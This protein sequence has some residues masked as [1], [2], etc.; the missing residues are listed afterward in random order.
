MFFEYTFMV[1]TQLGMS[2]HVNAYR[3]GMIF[4]ITNIIT[5]SFHYWNITRLLCVIIFRKFHSSVL[6]TKQHYDPSIKWADD[7]CSK[8]WKQKILCKRLQSML[9]FSFN[10]VSHQHKYFNINF[11]GLYF[12]F[13][14]SL[15]GSGEASQKIWLCHANF[16]SLSLFICLEIHCFY[17]LWTRKY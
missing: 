1:M 6:P 8:Y 5:Q 11:I 17:G 12:Y 10:S 9:C 4:E 15:Q 16:K 7:F 2:K 3:I 13:E 14:N